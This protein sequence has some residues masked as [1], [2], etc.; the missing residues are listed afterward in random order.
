MGNRVIIQSEFQ[1]FLGINSGGGNFGYQDWFVR[2]RYRGYPGR[3]WAPDVD[4][5][6]PNF[7]WPGRPA[8][9]YG[10]PHG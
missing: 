1:Y 6:W 4:V 9:P 8:V 5:D 2:N 7:D 10:W 3:P